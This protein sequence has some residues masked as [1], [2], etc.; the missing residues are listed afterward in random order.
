M[1]I[2]Q[3]KD[4]RDRLESFVLKERNKWNKIK[5]E[6]EEWI[7]FL[8]H[9]INSRAFSNIRLGWVWGQRHV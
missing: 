5:N 8:D 2:E 1:D 9:L 7:N 3:V 4:V 6:R